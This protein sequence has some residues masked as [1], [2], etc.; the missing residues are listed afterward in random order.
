MP[1]FPKPFFRTSRDW[2]VQLGK[3]QIK[4]ANGPQNADTEAQAFT[5]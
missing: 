1:E 5:R 2:Y 4:L 3:E